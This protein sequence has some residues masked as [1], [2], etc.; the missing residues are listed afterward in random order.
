MTVP[1]APS[2]R[3]NYLW[4]T[5]TNSS[6]QYAGIRLKW[7]KLLLIVPVVI[8]FYVVSY[9]WSSQDESEGLMVLSS[10]TALSELVQ[11]VPTDTS[12]NPHGRGLDSDPKQASS[13]LTTNATIRDNAPVAGVAVATNV[14]YYRQG[15]TWKH[16]ESASSYDEKVALKSI[17]TSDITTMSEETGW[18]LARRLPNATRNHGSVL[19]EMKPS[20]QQLLTIVLG[21]YSRALQ[22]IDLKTGY[23][24]ANHVPSSLVDPAGFPLNDLNHVFTVTVDS[25]DGTTKEIWLPCG[26]HGDA[27]NHEES[28]K[29]ARIV[30]MNNL[31]MTLGP[32]LAVAGGACVG[33][34][35]SFREKEPPHICTFGGTHGNHDTG[36]FLPYS[37]C[38]DRVQQKWH[39]PFGSL[40]MGLD[41]GS[42]AYIPEGRCH[43]NDPARILIL[44]FRTENY[45]TQSPLILAYDFPEVWTQ[46]H[47]E[48]PMDQPGG[49]YVFANVSYTGHN[50]EVNA[51][52]D[53]S[54]MV[55][56]DHGRFIVNMGGTHYEY[57]QRELSN[58]EGSVRARR[59]V[60]FATIRSFDVCQDRSKPQWVKLGDLGAQTFAIQTSA[61]TEL[62]MA[63]SCGGHA[64]TREHENLPWCF[65]SQFPDLSFENDINHYVEEQYQTIFQPSAA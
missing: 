5:C 34:A 39:F 45:G 49:W 54:G 56:A 12:G 23:R 35:V 51:P 59:H 48:T 42:L 52:R 50:D 57:Y 7:I 62:N 64:F 2:R 18:V 36:D 26:F 63:V 41:H 10:S 9:F 1:V 14:P 22:T 43:P 46:A 60:K 44:N 24:H 15:R 55:L 13:I 65:V 16:W 29:Y 19:F 37:S 27:V 20:Q 61:S 38:Y 40:P 8:P 3:R 17:G 30:H 53:A 6:S 4:T 28:S 32:K 21:R 58:G 11:N 33:M 31:S 47:F 25:L